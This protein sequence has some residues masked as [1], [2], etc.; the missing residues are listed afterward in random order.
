MVK[1][2]GS[3]AD[4]IY[5][6]YKMKKQVKKKST[7]T[8]RKSGKIKV[9]VTDDHAISRAGLAGVLQAERDII[10]V[11]EAVD[12]QDAVKKASKLNPDIVIMDVLMPQMDGLKAGKAIKQQLP[13]TKIIMLTI[14]ERE[15]HL[16]QALRFGAQGYLSKDSAIEEIVDAVRRVNEGKVMLSPPLATKLVAELR[17]VR[18]EPSISRREMQVLQMLGEGLSNEE[19]AKQLYISESTIR[20][21]IHRIMEK[22]RLKSRSEAVVYAI[23]HRFPASFNSTEPT[24]N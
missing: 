7:S 2:N 15:D 3:D 21:Y 5:H 19:M 6:G 17:D 18:E 16:F 4:I 23:N 24:L 13:D 10:V 12:G 22:L 11:G 1:T 8:S 20:T 14:S 9:L